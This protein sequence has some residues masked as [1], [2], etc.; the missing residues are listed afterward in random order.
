MAIRSTSMSC[1]GGH[2][3]NGFQNTASRTKAVEIHQ[4]RAGGASDRGP[5]RAALAGAAPGQG[6]RGAAGRLVADSPAARRTR[7]P[8]APEGESSS[9]HPVDAPDQRWGA[10]DFAE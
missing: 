4:G 5:P 8:A 9:G 10:N 1:R 6:R 2:E 7:Q 3:L